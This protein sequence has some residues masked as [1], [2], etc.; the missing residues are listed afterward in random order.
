MPDSKPGLMYDRPE[1]K[2]QIKMKNG[3]AYIHPYVAASDKR[4]RGQG[5]AAVSIRADR[6]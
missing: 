4:I 5:Q 2:L 6:Q 1:N 3:Q